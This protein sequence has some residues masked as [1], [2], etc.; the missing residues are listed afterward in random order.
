MSVVVF[1]GITKLAHNAYNNKRAK[2]VTYVQMLKN[3]AIIDGNISYKG[4]DVVILRTYQSVNT[5]N[6]FWTVNPD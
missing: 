6:M 2:I 1:P 5:Y 3:K 4:A